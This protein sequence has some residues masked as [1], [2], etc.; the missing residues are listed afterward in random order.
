MIVV[1]EYEIT[2][3]IKSELAIMKYI[4]YYQKV[5]LEKGKYA[6]FFFMKTLFMKVPYKI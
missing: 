6:M 3:R 1:F 2:S 5:A 4:I